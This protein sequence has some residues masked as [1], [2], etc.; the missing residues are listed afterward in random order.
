MGYIDY[1]CT[2]WNR[3]YFPDDFDLTSTIEELKDEIFD[4][5]SCISEN[6][7]STKKPIRPES[8]GGISTVVVYQ[9]DDTILYRNGC[10]KIKNTTDSIIENKVLPIEW[11]EDVEEII[12]VNS[13]FVKLHVE[14]ESDIE[15][16][17]NIENNDIDL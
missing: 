9:D 14:E 15:E 1:K 11:E 6:L 10:E 8:N 2:V 17:D 7:E 16:I 13:G 3:I 4:F 5:N 12:D